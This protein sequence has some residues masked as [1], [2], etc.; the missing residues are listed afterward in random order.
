VIDKL[1]IIYMELMTNEYL[2]KRF[3]SMVGYR[4]ARP[5]SII[6]IPSGRYRQTCHKSSKAKS[7]SKSKSESVAH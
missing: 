1:V 6:H 4:S 5:K 3:R 2:C 7:K